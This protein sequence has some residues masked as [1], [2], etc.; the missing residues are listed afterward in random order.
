MGGIL[1]NYTNIRDLKESNFG[2]T[3]IASSKENKEKLYVIK[4]L[5]LQNQQSIDLNKLNKGYENISIIN[6]KNILKYYYLIEEDKKK[7]KYDIVMEYC[8]NSDLREFINFHKKYNKKI[9]QNII[10]LI[11]LDICLGLKEIQ[12]R[13]LVHQDLQPKNIF[14]A[15]DGTIK[16]RGPSR[17]KYLKERPSQGVGIT[18][19]ISPELILGNENSKSTDIWSLGCILYELCTLEKCFNFEGMKIIPLADKINKMPEKPQIKIDTKIYDKD[20]Q[21][22]INLLLIKNEKDRINI[23]DAYNKI[24]GFLYKFNIPKNFFNLDEK[25]KTILH[26]NKIKIEI[27][28][29]KDDINQDIYFLDNT[30]LHDKLNK[31]NEN[32][33]ELFVNDKKNTF[34]K[35]F[36][37]L[38]E[39]KYNIILFINIRITDCSYMFYGCN[40]IIS[41][42]LSHFET[43]IVK[44]MEEMF[45]GCNNLSN[46][47]LSFIDTNNVTNMKNMFFLCDNLSSMDLSSFNTI[48]VTNMNG[49]FFWCT[50]LANINIPNFRTNNVINMSGMFF[51]CKSLKNLNLTSFDTEKVNDMSAMFY[52]C[53]NLISIELSAFGKNVRDMS[54]MFRYCNNLKTINAFYF[55]PAKFTDTSYI[56]DGCSNLIEKN[57]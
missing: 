32:N 22:L 50:N 44:N 57:F 38:K 31:L 46:L 13:N 10:Y 15:E 56:F 30:E 19:Y 33:T 1:S 41:I 45:C 20:L 17:N 39:G 4:Q 53:T 35:S 49:M 27:E 28:I 34:R 2:K 48:N 54:S 12:A 26:R 3:Y 16:I 23:N 9:N 24:I 40:S 18:N 42:D 11:I 36:K 6:H 25:S 47:D 29:K 37:F 52:K 21:D 5:K 43:H 7:K 55:K 8:E 51:G 14:I